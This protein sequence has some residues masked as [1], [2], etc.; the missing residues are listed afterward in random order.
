MHHHFLILA[1]LLND[2]T[3]PLVQSIINDNTCSWFNYTPDAW[4]VCTKN[5]GQILLDKLNAQLGQGA[6]FVVVQ[7]DAAQTIGGM[8]PDAG[9]KWLRK[10][11][12]MN[13]T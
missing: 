4:I 6:Y 7:V 13:R 5:N 8:L 12:L 2:F 3:R 9:W 10:H 1:G 11:H